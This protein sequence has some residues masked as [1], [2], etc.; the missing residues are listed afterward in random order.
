MI[1]GDKVDEEKSKLDE[2]IEKEFKKYDFKS[3]DKER[4]NMESFDTIMASIK[5]LVGKEIGKALFWI[6]RNAQKSLQEGEIEIRENTLV[7][8]NQF[9]ECVLLERDPEIKKIIIK[10]HFDS[11]EKEAW[12]FTEL[13]IESQSILWI[14]GK[15][16]NPDNAPNNAENIGIS[17]YKKALKTFQIILREAKK[18]K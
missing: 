9:Y 18:I 11:E 15:Y 17:T 7:R 1:K 13:E 5:N 2:L 14:K 12:Y 8:T 4:I 10:V 16:C 3:F 6:I